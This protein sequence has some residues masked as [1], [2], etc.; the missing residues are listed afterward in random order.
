MFGLRDKEIKR[1]PEERDGGPH[2][3]ISEGNFGAHVIT[4]I[5]RAGVRVCK[6]IY[7]GHR[8]N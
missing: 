4:L 3:G 6:R 2:E 1:G 7:V 8:N 5:R